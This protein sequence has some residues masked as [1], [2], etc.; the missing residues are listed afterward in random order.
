MTIEQYLHIIMKRWMV[1]VVC[2]VLVGGGAYVGS[3]LMT[4]LYQSTAIVEVIFNTG[5]NQTDSYTSL[6][7]SEQLLETETTLAT[8]DPVLHEVASHYPGFTAEQLARQ[9]TATAK[10][11][12]QLFQIDVVDSNANRAAR[13]ANDV[14]QTLINQQRQISQQNTAQSSVLL[15]IVQPAQPSRSPVQPQTLL[16][17][18]AGLVVGLLLGILLAILFELLD[19]RVRT[20]DAL[21]QMLQWPVLG[22]IWRAQSSRQQREDIVNPTGHNAYV[23]S[24][25]LL[26]SSIGFSSVDKPLRT[27]V[28]TSSTP[29]EGK[30]VVT[31]NLAIFMARAGK[32]V[33]LIDADLRRPSQHRIFDFPNNKMGLSNAILALRTP[34]MA[35]LPA[36]A[37]RLLNS[38]IHPTDI[39]NL[40][41]MPSGSLPPNP[42]ELLDSKAMQNLLAT[43]DSCGAE[44]V[45][46]DTPPLLGLS[47]ASI[48]A[49][50]VDGT[51]IVVDGTRARKRNIRLMQQVL[52]QANVH[53]LGCVMN[54]LRRTRRETTYP[55][56]Y[57]S[58][59]ETEL[60][61]LNTSE[62]RAFL[63]PDEPVEED[64][65]AEK[66]IALP[67][68]GAKKKKDLSLSKDRGDGEA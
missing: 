19:T 4:P 10:T 30:T 44:I 5:S 21:A 32:T 52:T 59:E 46:F 1:I 17:T 25:R 63:A 49:S 55:Y 28:V 68:P 62:V 61:R 40:F 20:T 37:Q 39:P 23:E 7:A 15:Y 29:G 51:I 16:N 6:L 42:S 47:D 18:G 22:T 64:P 12:T 27:L 26:R 24:Y 14:A 43:L 11:N 65:M 58:D 9:V 50:K 56:Y 33:F 38:F 13:I 45:I 66:T 60:E 8:S 48:L 54:K 41:L 31:A 57:A 2:F 67:K 53:V 34:N 35:S 3:K 36:N